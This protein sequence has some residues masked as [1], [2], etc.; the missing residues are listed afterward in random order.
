MKRKMLVLVRILL[1][2]C[3]L[4]PSTMLIRV[5]ATQ[6]NCQPTSPSC[7]EGGSCTECTY[8]VICGNFFAPVYPTQVFFCELSGC[9][10]GSF[11]FVSIFCG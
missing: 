10:Y 3:L 11:F 8:S 4:V 5:R 1:L 9:D 2:L 6:E 7:Y